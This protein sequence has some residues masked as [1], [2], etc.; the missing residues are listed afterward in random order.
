M[1]VLDNQHSGKLLMVLAAFLT[2]TGQMFWKLGHESPGFF[3]A[4]FVCYG[5]GALMMIQ[6][7]AREKLSVAYPLMCLSYIFALAYGQWLLSEPISMKGVAAVVLIIAGV[8][9]TSYD[10]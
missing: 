3:A 6:G 9:L 8:I 5:A 1:K 10:K 7:Y 4:G 2:A